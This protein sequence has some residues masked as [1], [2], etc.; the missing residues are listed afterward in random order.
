MHGSDWLW[1]TIRPRDP[2][3]LGDHKYVFE[4]YFKSGCGAKFWVEERDLELPSLIHADLSYVGLVCYRGPAFN[5]TCL[6]LGHLVYKYEV[7]WEVPGCASLSLTFFNPSHPPHIR[8]LQIQRLL[9]PTPWIV[10]CNVWTSW[11]RT[12]RYL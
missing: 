11:G 7:S 3:T 4:V 12:R 6:L 8:D 1:T 10:A 5:Y 2:K 9:A